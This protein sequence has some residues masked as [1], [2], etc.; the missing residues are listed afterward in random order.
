MAATRRFWISY[1]PDDPATHHKSLGIV[2]VEACCGGHAEA[3]VHE[4]G[5]YPGGIPHGYELVP[6]TPVGAR[7]YELLPLNTLLMRSEV[8]ELVRVAEADVD[9][10]RSRR[11]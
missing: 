7:L 10:R 5:L 2:V 9:G 1:G 8:D 6:T 4:L 3:R 11:N